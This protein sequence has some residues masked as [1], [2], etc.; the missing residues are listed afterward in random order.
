MPTENQFLYEEKQLYADT[1]W[2]F[3]FAK[4]MPKDYLVASLKNKLLGQQ[5]I[6]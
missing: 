3:L 5:I 2:F 4:P 6:C 1:N